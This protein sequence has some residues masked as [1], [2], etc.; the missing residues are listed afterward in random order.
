MATVTSRDPQEIVS[1][2]SSD[3]AKTREEG[4]KLLNTWLEG[5][6]ST[7]IVRYIGQ[8]TAMLKPSEI[9]H[10]F[11]LEA[12]TCGVVSNPFAYLFVSRDEGKLSSVCVP[13]L[14]TTHDH[15]LKD[16]LILYAW[17]QLNLTRGAADGSELVEH[18]WDVFG[19]ELD[20]NCICS[21]TN[22]AWS[23]TTKDDKCG[24]L[25]SSQCGVVELTALVFYRA[26]LRTT[27]A[28]LAE[29]RARKEHAA[30]YIKEGLMN[31][32]W[33]CKDLFAYWFDGI[34]ASFERIMNDATVS[35]AY[36]CL[37]WAL[38]MTVCFVA[39]M[40]VH[41]VLRSLHQLSSVLLLSVPGM[42]ASSN[43]TDRSWHT[44]WC[45]LMSGFPVFSNVA[46]VDST[47]TF[48]IP[49]DVW[50]LCLFKRLPSVDIG[51]LFISIES[52]RK[53]L[54]WVL[55]PLVDTEVRISDYEILKYAF[56]VWN[57]FGSVIAGLPPIPSLSKGTC[58]PLVWSVL[59]G[60]NH[61]GGL[62]D[63]LH[64][65]QNLLR[66]VLA[67]VNWQDCPMLNEGLVRFL[68]AAVYALCAG[69]APLPLDC[70]EL[71]LFHSSMDV[72]V[73]ECIK[74]EDFQND[75][76]HELFECSV[77]VL[78][79]IDHGSVPEAIS[80]FFSTITVCQSHCYQN[81]RLPHQLRVSLLEEMVTYILEA[82]LD[83][84]LEQ[85]LL[86]DLFYKCALLSS[87]MFGS[88]IRRVREV[89][90]FFGKMG[91]HLLKLLDCAISV[92][93][94]SHNDVRT[95]QN[96]IDV[97]VYT[98][99]SQSIERLLQAL[100]KL[101]KE[102]SPSSPNFQ[103]EIELP[104]FPA[105]I[106][107]VPTS[108]SNSSISMIMDMELDLS[109]D[110]KDLDAIA[111]GRKTVGVSVSSGLWKFHILSLIS[112][113]FEVLPVVALEILFDLVE[114]ENEAN[115]LENI[116]LNLCRHPHWSSSRQFSRLVSSMNNFV[117]LRTNLKLQCS[118]ILVAICDLLG[119][120]ISLDTSGK[121]T[122]T[123]GKEKNVVTS[124]R[125]RISEQAGLR[126]GL[127]TLCLDLS[128]LGI[129]F[130]IRLGIL[131]VNQNHLSVLEALF[132][133]MDKVCKVKEDGTKHVFI[134]KSTSI[135][136]SF[137]CVEQNTSAWNLRFSLARRIGTLFHTWDGHD[138]LFQDICSNF[139]AE[140]VV[141]SKEKVV[142]AKEALAA[143]PQPRPT[144]WKPLSSLSCIS[145][146]SKVVCLLSHVDIGCHVPAVFMMCVISAIDPSQRELVVA[147]LDNLSRQLQYTSRSKYLEE[148]MG[149]I[150]LSWVA[151]GVSL[152][153]L[154]EVSIVSHIFSQASSESDPMLP[155]FSKDAIVHTIQ[156]VDGFLNIL[157]TIECS[158]FSLALFI[159]FHIYSS[160]SICCIISQSIFCMIAQF[161]IEMHYK[162]TA[163]VHHRHKCHRLAGIEYEAA[164]RA[165]NWD[166]S[167][168][169]MG[170]SSSCLSQDPTRG[171]FHEHLYSCLR[172]LQEGDFREFHSTLRDSKQVLSISHAS[173][174]STEYIYSMIIKL[175]IFYHLDM[176]WNL[177]WRENMKSSTEMQKLLSEPDVP[178]LDQKS[179]SNIKVHGLYGAASTL[180]KLEEA[181]P[182]RAQGQHEMAI[183]LAKYISQNHQSSEVISDVY[184]L[185][186][187]CIAESRSSNSRTIL[188]KY[189][190]R[191][192]MFTEDR[193]MKKDFNEWQAAM[194]LRKHKGE[195]T[196]Y[197]V[198]N[199]ELQKQL[200]MDN[201]E[202]ERFQVFRLVSLW[203]SLSSRQLVVNGML[204]TIE[205]VQS[206]KF[207]PLVYQIA[208]R[209][210]SKDG[211]GPHSFQ[212]SLASLMKKMAID[213]PYHTIFQLIALANGDRIKD[214]Q[215]S[216]NSFVVDMDKK[217]ATENLLQELSSYHGAIIRQV[218][219]FT[220]S[221]GVLE[222][223]NGTLP[224]GEYL[225]GSKTCVK[226]CKLS[227]RFLFLDDLYDST[228][229]SVMVGYIVGLGD[230]HSM[231]ILIDQ[232]TAEVVHIDL[233]VPFRLTRDRIDGRGVNGVEGVFR[234]CCE[235]TL[236]VMRT[237]KEALLTIVEVFIHDP[238]YKWALSPLKALQRQKYADLPRSITSKKLDGL[239]YL[240]WAHAVKVYLCGQQQMKYITAPLPPKDDVT[241]LDWEQDD[242][243]IIGQLW[244]RK[245]LAEYYSALKSLWD[246]L[247]QHRPFTTD[248]E[249]QKRHW[250]DFMLASLLFGVDSD[251]K[252]FKDQILASETLPTATNAYSCPSRSSLGQSSSA[253]RSVA[254]PDS[255]ALV[256][257]SGTRGYRVGTDPLF[258]IALLFFY[259]YFSTF[260]SPLSEP[261]LQVYQRKK[262]RDIVSYGPV[263]SSSLSEE[264]ED[265]LET[266]LED[267]QEEYEGN[268][269][270]AR[271]PMRVKQK[272]DMKKV[273]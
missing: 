85:E 35:H 223:V 113:L 253:P 209:M 148:L 241:F 114:K 123:D 244:H 151:C 165:G 258:G 16:T 59:V 1:K 15:G 129:I 62:R 78:A 14:D 153:S 173:K 249:Q 195:K 128:L 32:R 185:V 6:R 222:W 72:L 23:D 171:H 158:E 259:R 44:I 80:S 229:F 46:S 163:A 109:E 203:F 198:K 201:E 112:S 125:E 214:K 69:C 265:N 140:L 179:S 126:L 218:V 192:V 43:E 240:S 8:K 105:C 89:S 235:D 184:R 137:G 40:Y 242:S 156:T 81:V 96:V 13:L 138:D 2:L 145:Q 239:N 60:L 190:K 119:T 130:A 174:E 263:P 143:G 83:K 142:T 181:K 257:H 61:G 247:L 262:T 77:E 144:K 196:D 243:L 3:K 269:D 216:R 157:N 127:G 21:T 250:E 170:D 228:A 93:E 233:G 55:E 212:F 68:P 57:G 231:N 167:L 226:L 95:D 27:K 197:S 52:R 134:G 270:A 217:L 70:K 42:E 73:E 118:N 255:S 210:G 50:D 48:T 75:S 175:Q 51:A 248:L 26:C 86:C 17:L 5:E 230:R 36:D 186:G 147:A 152:V 169:S 107:C 251:L 161:T 63:S 11:P 213:H 131:V 206:Y 215:R 98:A 246:Q 160:D 183:N 108:P 177:R 141:P 92:I 164:W 254:L 194:T 224:L 101:Y 18:L 116:L 237:N 111:V 234:R 19:K 84:E 191:A 136:L 266:S 74:G 180:R 273:K 39:L 172:A 159:D 90:P 103:S 104:D 22:L 219:P 232:A 121:D 124:L 182:L 204:N 272:L 193:V 146:C 106:S 24:N 135:R 37:L 82:L 76:L 132:Y 225:I 205:E 236:C 221:A 117:D 245:P 97:T 4:I 166:F 155:F 47:I 150:I 208:S 31:G 267:S 139:G 10:Y 238:L 271:A 34:C 71:F 252:R 110:S 53:S 207:L 20:Q 9:H 41:L 256:S 64:L 227:M 187:K 178:T 54:A 260:R 66:A 7:G 120:L 87:F 268:K 67:L 25:T 154:I 168:L 189:L 29:K 88:Y 102:C 28:P 58:M 202:D 12:L 49:Q 94:K 199:Q 122:S 264:T 100:V 162:V 211:H 56:T 149:S 188:E 33:L 99:I 91:Q 115:V 176:A 45:C 220:P 133:W 200:A 79:K 38:R 30:A 261:P 65:R